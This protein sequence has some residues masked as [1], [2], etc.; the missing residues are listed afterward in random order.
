[1]SI[2]VT[3]AF[4]QQFSGNVQML[5]QQAGSKLRGSVR[6]EPV[7]GKQAFF[8]QIGATAAR[9]RPSRHSDTPR[10]DTP[11]ARRRCVLEDWDQSPVP[12]AA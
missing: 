12:L 11:H 9:R 10:M 4:V 5:V 2:Q 1:M 7:T 3:T 6:L 8:D